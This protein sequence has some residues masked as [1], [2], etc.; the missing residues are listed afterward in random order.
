MCAR[1][2]TYSAASLR[3]EALSLERTRKSKPKG[4]LAG[5]AAHRDL[6]SLSAKTRILQLRSRQ[7][8]HPYE[9]AY[10]LFVP[11]GR[12]SHKR[13]SDWRVSHGRVSLR[14]VPHGRASHV[15]ASHGCVPHNIVSG[16]YNLKLGNT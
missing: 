2:S 3:S 7:I 13:A 8:D 11:H 14:H 9:D 10:D 1:W 5:A 12:A 4:N 16:C 15:R 6:L